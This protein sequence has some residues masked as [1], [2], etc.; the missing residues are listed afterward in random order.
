MQFRTRLQPFFPMK[1]NLIQIA[2]MFSVSL[3]LLGSLGLAVNVLINLFTDKRGKPFQEAK[4]LIFR[5]S[6]FNRSWVLQIFWAR[7]TE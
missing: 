7:C 1:G 4:R 5:I 3:V 6:L 2:G